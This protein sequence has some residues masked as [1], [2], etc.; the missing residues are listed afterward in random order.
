MNYK[1]LLKNVLLS[2][3][4]VVTASNVVFAVGDYEHFFCKHDVLVKEATFYAMNITHFYGV[5]LTGSAYCTSSNLNDDVFMGSTISNLYLPFFEYDKD[6]LFSLFTALDCIDFQNHGQTI[7][8]PPYYAN[9]DL[10]TS[11]QACMNRLSAEDDNYVTF[12]VRPIIRKVRFYTQDQIQ[13][14]RM[15]RLAFRRFIKQN[16]LRRYVKDVNSDQKPP[17]LEQNLWDDL[18]AHA[19]NLMTTMSNVQPNG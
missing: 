14:I 4:T 7:W 2:V 17:R 11:M 16:N 19:N 1:K 9:I 18:K 6:S 12:D 8:L 15:Q 13:T 5:N 3:G 10:E